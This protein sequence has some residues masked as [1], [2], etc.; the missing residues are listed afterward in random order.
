MMMKNKQT[1]VDDAT[2]AAD[3]AWAASTGL[4]HQSAQY[5]ANLRES[6]YSRYRHA[7]RV[8]PFSFIAVMRLT[9]YCITGEMGLGYTHTNILP[10]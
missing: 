7:S 6:A 4:H 5:I 9:L 2:A 1:A 3:A 8:F 10:C